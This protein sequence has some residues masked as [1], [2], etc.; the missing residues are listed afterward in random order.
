MKRLKMRSHTQV[1][2]GE[3]VAHMLREHGVVLSFKIDGRDK[4]R[5]V[6]ARLVRSIDRGDYERVPGETI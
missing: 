2:V 1:A 6:L 5:A 4:L 3:I